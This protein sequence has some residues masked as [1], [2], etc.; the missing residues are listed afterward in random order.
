MDISDNTFRTA[1]TPLAAF[2]QFK[3]HELL[4]I[5]LEDGRGFFV[6]KDSKKLQQH[7]YDFHSSD[8]SDYYRTYRTLLNLLNMEMRARNGRGTTNYHD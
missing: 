2:L 6:F 4:G 5:K 3:K 1:D 8:Y 7:C